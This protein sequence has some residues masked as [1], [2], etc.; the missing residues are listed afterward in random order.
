MLRK[1]ILHKL[2]I[3]QSNFRF[4][5]NGQIA[6]VSGLNWH[7]MKL[8]GCHKVVLHGVRLHFAAMVFSWGTR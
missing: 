2:I 3:I 7:S 4:L 5:Q 8:S 1:Y 6:S